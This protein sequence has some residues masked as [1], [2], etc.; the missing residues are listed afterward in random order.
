MAADLTGKKKK[1]KG[2]EKKVP[3]LYRTLKLKI[4]QD[5]STGPD[6]KANESSPHPPVLFLEDPF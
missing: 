2:G 1:K 4:L 3:A 5:A 6:L